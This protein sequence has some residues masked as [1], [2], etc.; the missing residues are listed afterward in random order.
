MGQGKRK[1]GP[2]PGPSSTRRLAAT[3]L[4]EP[5]G[6][7]RGRR[8]HEHRGSPS[9]HT[10]FHGTWLTV[11]RR[12]SCPLHS[13]PPAQVGRLPAAGTLPRVL[14]KLL[15]GRVEHGQQLRLR[16]RGQS[17]AQEP[18]QRARGH[19]G[20]LGQV[21]GQSQLLGEI[22]QQLRPSACSPDEQVL[23]DSW[24]GTFCPREVNTAVA[25]C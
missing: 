19:H 2:N 24:C 6:A 25:Q 21:R 23:T 17:H 1:R 11:F 9:P 16:G 12:Q 22:R 15:A 3:L 20:Q 5:R 4:P 13:P 18:V 14:W 10:R 7:G 8:V